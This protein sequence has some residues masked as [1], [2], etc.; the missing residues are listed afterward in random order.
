M[1]FDA[2]NTLRRNTVP[3]RVC[4]YG[5]GEW[6]PMPGLREALAGVRWGAPGG[7]PD[8]LLL[9]VASNQDHVAYGHLAAA[10]AL[11]LLQDAAEAV[12]GLRPE[13]E[14]TRFCPHRVDAG[15]RCRKPEPGLLLDAMAHHRVG[16]QA[17]LLV[18]DAPVDREAAR[19][20]GVRF[21]D[22]VEVLAAREPDLPVPGA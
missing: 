13:P 2:D 4:P 14:A 22:V 1:I 6:E 11:R 5:P 10:M 16:A 18:G 3:G 9:A 20:A 7:P 12:T 21:L 8:G 15:C 17:T 19:R